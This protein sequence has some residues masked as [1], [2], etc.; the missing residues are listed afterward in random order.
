VLDKALKELQEVSRL[1]QELQGDV[2]ACEDSLRQIVARF[3]T[4][5]K[6]VDA[7]MVSS[8]GYALVSEYRIHRLLPR[9]HVESA[10]TLPVHAD[11]V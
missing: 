6:S 11:E 7:V 4:W 9:Q 1:L 2:Q 5:A 10:A 8:G 3:L